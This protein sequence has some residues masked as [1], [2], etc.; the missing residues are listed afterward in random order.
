MTTATVCP[1]NQGM[2]ALGEDALGHDIGSESELGGDMILSGTEKDSTVSSTTGSTVSSTTLKMQL[3]AELRT[4]F[5]QTEKLFSC[6][7]PHG[8]FHCVPPV[9]VPHL[10][11]YGHPA[12]FYIERGVSIGI[13]KR[14]ARVDYSLERFLGEMSTEREIDNVARWA[15][16]VPQNAQ[17]ETVQRIREYRS[18]VL[19][20]V[21]QLIEDEDVAFNSPI[22][23]DSLHWFI[24]MGIEHDR[25]H[26]ERSANLLTQTPPE[27]LQQP[28]SPFPIFPPSNEKARANSLVDVNGGSVLIGR[29]RLAQQHDSF[30]WDN[31]FGDAEKVCVRPFSVSAMLV[32]NHEYR[33]FID[34][35]GYACPEYWSEAG[36]DWKGDRGGI[37]PCWRNGNKLRTLLQEI[38]M[39]ESWPAIVNHFEAE[40]FCSWKSKQI[41]R[42]LRLISRPEWLLL[43]KQLKSNCYNV[44]LRYSS[45]SPV[46]THGESLGANG[47][48]IYDVMGNAWQHSASPFTVQPGFQPHPLYPDYTLELD[49]LHYRILGGCWASQGHMTNAECCQQFRRHRYQMAG[50]RYVESENE[51][52]LP[53][54]R[55]LPCSV[56]SPG[57]VLSFWFDDPTQTKTR[58]PKW[59]APTSSE[60]DEEIL[61]R[62]GATLVSATTGRIDS[63]KSTAE[64]A[65]ALV[66]VVDQFAKRVFR[67]R[68][69]AFSH[70]AFTREVVDII[71]A[72]GF[73]DMYGPAG[74]F[75]GVLLPLKKADPAKY[76]KLLQKYMQ[77]PEMPPDQAKHCQLLTK[78]LKKYMQRHDSEEA[79]R[80]SSEGKLCN[81]ACRLYGAVCANALADSPQK[82]DLWAR[83]TSNPYPHVALGQ[84][85]NRP[86]HKCG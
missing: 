5:E 54:V 62:F 9:R 55:D 59:F 56:V 34:S 80:L 38:D 58:S 82:E 86:E 10:F 4:V 79:C 7:K 50:F 70:E 16:D 14:S 25:I 18:A 77:C 32:S 37:P 17:A 63:W 3:Q 21:C 75:F 42:T 67:G 11:F 19:E 64:G 71:L 61:L 41:G 49:G 78:L 72:Q 1:L 84:G 81:R 15:A 20:L 60:Y 68:S 45:H 12:A 65:L 76:D 13:L 2:T 44:N 35:G 51:L 26:F 47:E 39:Q 22:S 83:L 8:F 53:M 24:R 30:G 48:F 43:R 29:G 31:E 27:L 52:D 28:D 36:L 40:A 66:I 33:E 73:D 69:G 85:S 57:D 74:K 6:L 23:T 46:H